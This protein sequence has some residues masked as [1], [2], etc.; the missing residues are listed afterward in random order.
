MLARNASLDT[1]VRNDSTTVAS[2][3]PP[4]SSG[5]FDFTASKGF[6]LRVSA[7][8]DPTTRTATWLLQAIDPETGE[9]LQDSAR[10]LLAPND[11]QGRGAGYVSYYA[12]SA[13]EAQS[14]DT[15]EASA[16][17]IFNTQAPFDTPTITH[18]LDAAA[19]VT[20][21]TAT[22]V[23][24]GGADYDVRW[25][26]TDEVGGSGVKHTTVYVSEDGGSWK[27]WLRQTTETSG[28][29]NTV[30]LRPVARS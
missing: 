26:A 11:A 3:A 21:L 16:R 29:S 10:G 18:T 15:I 25:T 23:T 1:K 9:L 8:I 22:P 7:G 14:G 28:V 13:F 30:R 2:G 4:A 24:P 20:T 12:Q 5:D 19:P 6:V 27:I 17:V